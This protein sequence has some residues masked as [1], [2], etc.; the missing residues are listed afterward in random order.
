MCATGAAIKDFAL[1]FFRFNQAQLLAAAK[2]LRRKKPD[3]ENCSAAKLVSLLPLST[4]QGTVERIYLPGQEQR[5]KMESWRQKYIY[6]ARVFVDTVTGKP[7]IYGGQEGFDNFQKV[8]QNQLQLAID[9][10]LSGEYLSGGMQQQRWHS[11]R[12]YVQS[13]A[14]DLGAPSFLIVW[15]IRACANASDNIPCFNSML[16]QSQ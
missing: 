10:Y 14:A 1:C 9:E 6:D 16:V 2:A 3:Y 5:D 7:L 8:Y 12:P 11:C 15:W 4:W 13:H